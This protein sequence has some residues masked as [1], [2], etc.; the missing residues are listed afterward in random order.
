[1]KWEETVQQWRLTEQTHSEPGPKYCDR[2]G[3]SNDASASYCV[4]CGQALNY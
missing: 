2:C 4:A 1:M 3:A